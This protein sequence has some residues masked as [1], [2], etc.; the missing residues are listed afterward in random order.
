MRNPVIKTIIRSMSKAPVII[1]PYDPRWPLQFEEEKSH[2]VADIGA[3]TLSIEHIGST[4]VPGLAAKPVI[5]ILIGVRSLEDA[6]FFIPPL[7]C[8]WLH[9]CQQLRKRDAR[10]PLPA[11]P[12]QRRAHPS[13]AHG[14]SEFKFLPRARWHSE[15]SCVPTPKREVPTL[16]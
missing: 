14:A 16:P 11:P 12:R 15:I 10:S 1:L 9:L 8:P 2:I 3:F 5:D 4:A 13:S 7:I 6:S